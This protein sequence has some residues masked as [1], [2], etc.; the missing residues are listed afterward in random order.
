MTSVLARRER[1][2]GR[3][4]W[5]ACTR[6]RQ[7][8]RQLRLLDA[9]TPYR[10]ERFDPDDILAQDSQIPPAIWR[11]PVSHISESDMKTQ[12]TGPAVGSNRWAKNPFARSISSTQIN[13]KRLQKKKK[14]NTAPAPAAPAARWVPPPATESSPT[15][16]Q[17]ASWFFLFAFLVDT[18]VRAYAPAAAPEPEPEKKSL[19]KLAIAAGAVAIPLAAPHVGTALAMGAA[20][21]SKI[22]PAAPAAASFA[23]ALVPSAAPVVAASRVAPVAIILK[24]W[25]ALRGVVGFAAVA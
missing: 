9:S 25:R 12:S 7:V 20:A 3:G 24:V 18:A 21:V 19:P 13:R 8:S 5:T 1:R 15:F 17:I 23:K 4:P 11:V 2:L 22:V 6:L 16:V 14:A 10:A